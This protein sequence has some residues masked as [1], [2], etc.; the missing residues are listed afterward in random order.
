LGIVTRDV[1]EPSEQGRAVDAGMEREVLGTD[2]TV[3]DAEV[4]EFA[5]DGYWCADPERDLI[6]GDVPSVRP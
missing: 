3:D 2:R 1:V 4:G 6:R 5:G